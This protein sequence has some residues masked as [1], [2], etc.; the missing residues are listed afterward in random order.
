MVKLINIVKASLNK[1]FGSRVERPFRRNNSA[2]MGMLNRTTRKK[3]RTK[4]LQLAQIIATSWK[5]LATIAG[6]LSLIY[7][8]LPSIVQYSRTKVPI[9]KCIFPVPMA[10][11][12]SF[13][14]VITP[15]AIV[16]QNNFLINGTDGYILANDLYKRLKNDI[17][18]LGLPISYDIREPEFT[19]PIKGKDPE[20]RKQVARNL[21]KKIQADI[22]IFGVINRDGNKG[23]FSPEFYVNYK[24]FDQGDEITGEYQLGESLPLN[25]PLDEVELQQGVNKQYIAREKA[26]ILI[27][28]GLSNLAVDNYDDAIK[29]FQ[30]ADNI[31][32]WYDYQGKAV[33]YLL[34]GG[35]S[36]S[37]A[38]LF[39]DIPPDEYKLQLE[40][41]LTYYNKALGLDEQYARAKLG[42]A[43]VLYLEALGD[44]YAEKNQIDLDK[45]IEAEN[46]YKDI[47]AMPDAQ[48]N[49]NILSKVYYGYGQI[50]LARGQYDLAEIE[51]LK[52]IK[53]YQG[54][55]ESL[56]TT[57]S[58][59]YAR[60][61]WIA[62][63]RKD[64]SHAI[65]FIQKAIEHTSPYYRDRY[66]V[67][68]GDT[69]WESGDKE[70]GCSELQTALGW[71]ENIGDTRTIEELR[72]FMDANCK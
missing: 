32:N 30:S 56:E 23:N 39:R 64:Y 17:G 68:L 70:R 15:F 45:M 33:L 7:F 4:L 41:A 36:Q 57:A 26:L 13:N 18:Q 8:G 2:Q 19:C 34:M 25:L 10:K 9:I 27:V 1:V 58:H 47:L 43:N 72:S 37:K 49:S 66:S 53:L 69:Y 46:A 24:G 51:F 21:A 22:V 31:P 29:Q 65:E 28:L 38:T 71:A 11:D 59:A 48:G 12:P 16:D 61:G 63:Q 42:L 20:R 55:D 50:H 35:A 52:V 54:Q 62:R 60:L 14:I 6:V 44:L 67:L 5:K 40:N 3:I